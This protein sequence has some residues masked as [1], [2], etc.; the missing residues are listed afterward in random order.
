[1]K[2]NVKGTIISNNEKWIYDLFEKDSTAPKD[3]VLPETNEPIDVVINS[4][5]GDVYAG[6]EIYTALRA[7]QGDVTVQIVG[8]AASAASVIA[9][10]GNKVEISPTAQMMVHNVQSGAVGDHNVLQHEADVLKNYNTS[11]A[12]A[13]VA[14]TGKSMDDLLELMNASTWLTADQ[15]VENGFADAVMFQNTEAPKLVADI[16]AAIPSDVIE[17]VTNMLKPQIDIDK[18]AELVTSKLNEK[19]EEPKTTSGWKRFLF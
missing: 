8:I 2:I 7:Y 17:K 10:A 14:K 16:S 18:V 13:Y 11:I 19:K 1:M 12:N 5:G 6:S 15:A 3:I 4:G 9:M